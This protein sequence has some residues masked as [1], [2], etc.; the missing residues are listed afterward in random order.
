MMCA[1]VRTILI[2]QVINGCQARRLRHFCGALSGRPNITRRGRDIQSLI[3]F[4]P[5]GDT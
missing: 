5:H 1:L 2:E 4:F 3:T